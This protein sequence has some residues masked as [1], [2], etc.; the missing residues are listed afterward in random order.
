[1]NK[2]LLLNIFASYM[3]LMLYNKQASAQ[4]VGINT[5]GATP[6]AS[7]MLDV[8]SSNKGVLIPRV[9]LTGTTDATTIPSP[10]T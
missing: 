1:M 2:K 6:A 4:N 8:S 3:M 10:A 5:T 7:A 9:T